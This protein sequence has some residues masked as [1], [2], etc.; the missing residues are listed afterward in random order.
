MLLPTLI[1][2]A[3]RCNR[4]Q[5][6]AKYP[7]YFL[8]LSERADSLQL[9]FRTQISRGGEAPDPSG[10]VNEV[11]PIRKAAGNPYPDRIS[12]GRARN[13]DIVVRHESVSKLHAHFRRRP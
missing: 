1:T 4:D 12:I 11:L 3:N 6:A 10:G 5:F 7:G 9:G 2:D 8:L 13:C